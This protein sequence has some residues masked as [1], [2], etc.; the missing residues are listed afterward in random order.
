[1]SLK[2]KGL[3][4]DLK[5]SVVKT[6]LETVQVNT[7][8]VNELIEALTALILL[9]EV[10]EDVLEDGKISLADLGAGTKLLINANVIIQGIKGISEVP[11]ELL[12]LDDEELNQVM[13]ALEKAELKSI[14]I[15]KLKLIVTG[16]YN[17]KVGFFG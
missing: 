9:A 8:G 1:M 17:L 6:E 7:K 15:E 5:K 10:T 13:L 16:L 2:P 12:N 3:D 11:E 4:F 14:S